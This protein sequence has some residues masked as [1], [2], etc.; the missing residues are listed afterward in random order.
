LISILIR[1]VRDS[2][3]KMIIE[4]VIIIVIIRF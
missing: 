2:R 4:F 1:Y 3:N